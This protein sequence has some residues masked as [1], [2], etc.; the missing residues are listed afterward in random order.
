MKHAI[1]SFCCFIAFFATIILFSNNTHA[2]SLSSTSGSFIES[3][4]YR[5]D[6]H[7]WQCN[8]II[9]DR[10]HGYVTEHYVDSYE[11][12][13]TGAIRF[14]S[15]DGTIYEIPYPYFQVEKFK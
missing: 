14:I 4:N 3:E 11:E 8:Y 5:E 1:Y 7:D 15:H 6:K 12:L 2:L 9:H 13:V 10:Y